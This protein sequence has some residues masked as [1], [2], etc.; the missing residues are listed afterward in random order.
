MK[1]EVTQKKEAHQIT[2]N[3]NRMWCLRL[4][5]ATTAGRRQNARWW[6]PTHLTDQILVNGATP[7]VLPAAVP[8]TWVPWPSQSSLCSGRMFRTKSYLD[9]AAAKRSRRRQRP[10]HS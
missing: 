2:D 10:V 9:A 4:T 6:A 7:T 8:A 3:T 1:E 5:A